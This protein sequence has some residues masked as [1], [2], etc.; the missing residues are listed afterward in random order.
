M[1]RSV[2]AAAGNECTRTRRNHHR[3]QV[4]NR[5]DEAP[6]QGHSGRKW[7]QPRTAPGTQG[8]SHS[9]ALPLHTAWHTRVVKQCLSTSVVFFF[10]FSRV[11]FIL[12]HFREKKSPLPKALA[13]PLHSNG[14]GT[15]ASKPQGTSAVHSSAYN[16]SAN[17]S[18][19]KQ[20]HM[21][22]PMETGVGETFC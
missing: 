19:A 3:H 22:K 14:R 15:R 11:F 6:A 17:I 9:A 8:L 13:S 2:T 18:L 20:S 7:F 10:Y 5:D 12:E 16:T 1:W 4:T 21:A